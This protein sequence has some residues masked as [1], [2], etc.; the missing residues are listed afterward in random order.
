MALNMLPTVRT[1]LSKAR[2][3]FSGKAS[4]GI[5]TFEEKTSSKYNDGMNEDKPEM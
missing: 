3:I 2:E 4:R 1:R 5:V